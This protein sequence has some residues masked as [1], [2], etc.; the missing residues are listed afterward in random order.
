MMNPQIDKIAENIA[1]TVVLL[2]M[3]CIYGA[4][5]IILLLDGATPGSGD[6]VILG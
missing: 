4:R 3:V 5:L 1:V 6:L 2:V